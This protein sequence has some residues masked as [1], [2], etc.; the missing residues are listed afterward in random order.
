MA[1]RDMSLRGRLLGLLL[2]GGLLPVAAIAWFVFWY[3][4]VRLYDQLALQ[5]SITAEDVRDRVDRELY[6]RFR[7][8]KALAGDPALAAAPGAGLDR[9]LRSDSSKRGGPNQ[10]V[11]SC[12]E[13]LRGDGAELSR[14]GA[15]GRPSPP[16][17]AEPRAPFLALASAGGG[18]PAFDLY[19]PISARGRGAGWLRAVLDAR[20]LTD[21]LARTKLGGGLDAVAL[22]LAPGGAVVARRAAAD[23]NAPADPLPLLAA[24][25]RA[26]A[27]A[28][29]GPIAPGRDA[30]AAREDLVGLTPPLDSLH[31][32]IAIVQPLDDLS[33]Q[34]VLLLHQL[35]RGIL[36]AAAL[37]VFT[38]LLCALLLFRAIMRP[39]NR[40]TEA[41][42]RVQRG[43]LTTEIEIERLDEFGHLAVFFNEMTRKLKGS[44]DE[45]SERA[46][47]DA[48]T[49]LANRRAF[50]EKLGAELK[51]VERYGRSLSLALLDVDHF[52][53][54]NDAHGHAFG[55]AVL[56]ELGR[57]CARGLRDTDFVARYGGEEIAFVFPETSKKD[58]AVVLERLRASIEKLPVFDDASGEALC[59]TV[60]IGLAG[61]PDDAT[62]E[63][64]LLAL[65]DKALYAAKS[66]GLNR[67]VVA[68]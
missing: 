34:T 32:R 20:P 37:A 30:V 47:T 15:C 24:L 65:A 6:G 13:V 62:D 39:L 68:G 11:Y 59:V 40:L 29:R 25:E 49:G 50:D 48:L 54:C 26:R 46:A 22:I 31:W 10:G 51:R 8:L 60:S 53:D 55:D 38:S 44:R 33:E 28:G 58:A 2:L 27:P 17:P 66:G 63:K 23:S 3:I 7:D 61:F 16:S 18:A 57:V 36:T 4:E 64:D 21:Q 19:L 5:L 1:G 56:R 43:D 9:F 45:L 52:K 42:L 41:T 14:R 12:L 35:S 67:V